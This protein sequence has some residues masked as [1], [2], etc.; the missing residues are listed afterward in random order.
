MKKIE[1]K[2]LVRIFIGLNPV[3]ECTLFRLK[4]Q[5]GFPVGILV[6]ETV[7]KNKVFS[8]LGLPAVIPFQENMVDKTKPFSKTVFFFFEKKLESELSIKDYLR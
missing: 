3:S 2:S 8:Q 1:M 4:K 6:W 5:K 7:D